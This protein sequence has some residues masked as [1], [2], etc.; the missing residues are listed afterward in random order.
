MV[1][2]NCYEKRTLIKFYVEYRKKNTFLCIES[3]ARED[4]YQHHHDRWELKT[5]WG[6]VIFFCLFVCI[7]NF[8]KIKHAL[9]L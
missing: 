3:K 5:S 8:Q 1:T 9:I 2:S 7:F 4:P 6:V